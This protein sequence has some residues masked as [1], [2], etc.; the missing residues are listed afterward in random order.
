MTLT[1]LES[2]T[3]HLSVKRVNHLMTNACLHNWLQ[4]PWQRYNSSLPARKS[5]HTL[6]GEQ[7]QMRRPERY[8][9]EQGTRIRM[10]EQNGGQ[11]REDFDLP[12]IDAD[13]ISIHGFFHLDKCISRHLM[14]KPTTP[15]MQHDAD[16]RMNENWIDQLLLFYCEQ[17]T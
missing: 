2:G 4:R 17:H 15:A 3:C 11:K 13:L 1:S 7:R 6:A 12:I 16:L 14:T 10:T 8:P 5:A 9:N